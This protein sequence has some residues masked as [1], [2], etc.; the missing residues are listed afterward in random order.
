[1]GLWKKG[2]VTCVGH[3]DGFGLACCYELLHLLP[4]V[5]VVVVVDDVARAVGA[6]GEAVIVACGRRLHV[7]LSWKGRLNGR[8]NRRL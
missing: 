3:A 1:L 6:G 4:G 7:R 5:D 8:L 2:G